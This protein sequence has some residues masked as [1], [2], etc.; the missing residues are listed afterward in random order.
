MNK[1]DRLTLIIGI[2]AVIILS[3]SAG[4]A[5][6]SGPRF[7]WDD[8]T[9]GA[10]DCWIDGFDDGREDKYKQGRGDECRTDDD[11]NPYYKG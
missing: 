7:D 2:A 4:T 5:F 9:P 8:S 6:A 3:V 1:K 10:P 11:D